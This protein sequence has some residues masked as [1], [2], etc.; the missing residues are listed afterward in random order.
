[1]IY[2]S[3]VRQGCVLS[4]LLFLVNID[5]ITKAANV[6]IENK[7]KVNDLLFADDQVLIAKDEKLLK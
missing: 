3:G 2:T 1:L 5:N 4:P 7:N 6:T